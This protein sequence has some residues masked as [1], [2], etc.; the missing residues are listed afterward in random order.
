[1]RN[2]GSHIRGM[3]FVAD[4]ELLIIGN[5]AFGTDGNLYHGT[6]SFHRVFA[7]CRL[8][9]KHDGAC[10]LIN[11]VGNVCCL[12]TGGTWIFDHGIKH[13]CGGDNLFACV[14]YFVD[15]FF[16]DHRNIFQRDFHTHVAAGDH[17]A[18][19]SFN[20]AVDVVN[21]LLVFDFCNNVQITAAV[22][23]EDFPDFVDVRRSSGE[24]CRDEIKAF[25]NTEKDIFSVLFADKR[26]IDFHAG[27][28]NAFFVGNNAAV[29]DDTVDIMSFDTLYFH[30]DQ[31]VVY[32]NTVA[33]FHIFVQIFV[34]NRHNVFISLYFFRGQSKFLTFCQGHLSFCKFADTDLRALCIKK[35]SDRSVQTFPDFH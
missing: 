13:L 2:G 7:G 28:I 12:R 14:V 9:G 33:G 3:V 22:F 20:N 24:G 17:D 10:T 21:A 11:C 6:E 1:M 26:H 32:K 35:R 27:K 5:V 4:T 18:V 30:A 23:V 8:A 34:G 19:G 16:L 15:D 31:T 29:F 25:L